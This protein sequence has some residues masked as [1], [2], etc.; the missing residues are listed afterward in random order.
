MCFAEWCGVP[1]ENTLHVPSISLTFFVTFKRESFEKCNGAIICKGYALGVKCGALNATT[2]REIQIVA[3]LLSG[4]AQTFT[5]TSKTPVRGST[6]L[7][8]ITVCTELP[9]SGLQI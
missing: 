3:G 9:H 7:L 8:R 5:A 1:S 2:A 4:S 6:D